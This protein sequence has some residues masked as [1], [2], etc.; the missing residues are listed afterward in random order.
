MQTVRHLDRARSAC[1]SSELD[2]P[3][4]RESL[5]LSTQLADALQHKSGEGDR[6]TGNVRARH[7]C[8]NA[9][10]VQWI[11]GAAGSRVHSCK[12]LD[13]GSFKFRR[14]C[15][16][17]EVSTRHA[18]HTLARS[19]TCSCSLCMRQ[20]YECRRHCSVAL[21]SRSMF[22]FVTSHS[23]CKYEAEHA[24]RRARV[25]LSLLYHRVQ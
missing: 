3:S 20:C 6:H 7:R 10:Q 22:E 16:L 1:S 17:P 9:I 4:G 19:A 15:S 24:S 13:C 18:L 2:S 12:N 25:L 21:L 8:L 23:T 11:A 14:D 5:S